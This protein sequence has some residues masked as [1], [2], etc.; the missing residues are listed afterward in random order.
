MT[1]QAIGFSAADRHF[2]EYP[3]M[4]V[5]PIRSSACVCLL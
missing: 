1:A 3:R 4:S 5:L 2:R